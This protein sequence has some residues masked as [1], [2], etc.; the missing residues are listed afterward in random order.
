MYCSSQSV[1]KHGKG[2]LGLQRYYCSACNQTFQSRQR[3]KHGPVTPAQIWYEYVWGK[4]TI[5]QLVTKYGKS[6]KWIQQQFDRHSVTLNNPF[7]YKPQP[8]TLAVD[9][10]HLD[11]TYGVLVFRATD[12]KVN[13]CWLFAPTERVNDYVRGVRF[14]QRKG[15]IILS[16]TV[17][18]K[19]GVK[20]QFRDIPLQLCQW[21]QQENICRYTTRK[22][23]LPANQELLH[24]TLQLT[25]LTK[26]DFTQRLTNWKVT[27]NTFLKEKTHN[28]VTGKWQYTHR[29]TRSALRSYERTLPYLFTY[30]Q[31]SKPHIPNTTNS[32]EGTFSQLQVK[33]Q[34]HRG[35]RGERKKKLIRELLIG[36]KLQ[37]AT[38]FSL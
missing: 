37:R 15:W 20:E 36:Q 17:D 27:W 7:P 24:L 10:C 14:L 22:P 1:K 16:L 25:N 34:C 30:Q 3:V 31:Y 12:L 18:G 28:P 29:R 8:I 33:L 5:A 26:D 4:Q 9:F 19:Q 21:H 13:L 11:E 38:H 35:I 32:L 6:Q 23:N 2:R